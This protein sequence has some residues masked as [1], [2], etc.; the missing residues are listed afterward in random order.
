VLTGDADRF[1]P[2]GGVRDVFARVP[3]PK[4]MFVLRGGDHGHF[5]D[6]VDPTGPTKEQAHLFTR[7]L[8]LA[9]LDATLK[10]DEDARRYLAGDV[11]G[12]LRDRGV[13]A[14]AD[15]GAPQPAR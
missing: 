8:A 5:A 2:L 9:H 15:E 14:F 11:D 6:E 4:R 13:D 12:D 7:G 3:Q 10:A 1:T